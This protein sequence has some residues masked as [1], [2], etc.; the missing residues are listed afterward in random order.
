[1]RPEFFSLIDGDQSEA[2]DTVTIKELI[3]A[4]PSEPIHIVTAH[5]TAGLACADRRADK[6]DAR[7]GLCL[8]TL[9]CLCAEVTWTY[10][11]PPW[12]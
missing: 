12:G 9:L 10:A 6:I 4:M 7:F 5:C 11:R 2:A 3:D 1:M 8:Q